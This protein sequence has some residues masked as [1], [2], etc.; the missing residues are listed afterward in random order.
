MA[1]DTDSLSSFDKLSFNAFETKDILLEIDTDPDSNFFNESKFQNLDSPYYTP[2]ELIT[3]SKEISENMFSIFH[4]NI[5][6][7]NKNFENLK[8][9][10]QEIKHDFKVVSLSESRLKDENANQNSL[11]QIPNYI[12]IHQIRKGSSKGGGVSIYI[13]KTLNYKLRCDKS[14]CNPD[15]EA[16]TIEIIKENK[17]NLIITGIYRPPRSDEKNFRKEY[18]KLIENKNE[19]NKQIFLIGDINLNSL[20]YETNNCVKNFFNLS[21]K[22]SIFPIITRLTRVTRTST[23]E[24]KLNETTKETFKNILKNY[25]WDTV[26]NESNPNNAYDK[27]IEIHGSPKE[28][29]NLLKRNKN[30]TR[31]FL[32]KVLK[33]M[34]KFIKLTKT[35]LRE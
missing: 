8:N 21:F 22:N 7:V 18:K 25:N 30:F 1:N 6:S 26:K 23:K 28:S 5:R 19:I 15:I 11:Y 32:K 24:M 4:L 17:K 9:L 29:K 10:L 34:R 12:P 14:I 16:L 3:F 2:E 20:D 33:K 31:N 13:H 35:F 27:F